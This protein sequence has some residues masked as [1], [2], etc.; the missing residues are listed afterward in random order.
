MREEIV[1]HFAGNKNID[2]YM[3]LLREYLHSI[4]KQFKEKNAEQKESA[5]NK[6]DVQRY[7]GQLGKCVNVFVALSRS[8]SS[9]RK[10][11]EFGVHDDMTRLIGIVRDPFGHRYDQMTPMLKS[12][13]H[14][15]LVFYDQLSADP[16]FD[17]AFSIPFDRDPE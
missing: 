8:T 6:K 17:D 13:K 10:L 9:H 7:F 14:N 3:S 5:E 12:C 4:T 15:M 1:A 11:F 16:Q 2:K